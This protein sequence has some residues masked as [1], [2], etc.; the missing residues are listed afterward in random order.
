MRLKPLEAEVAGALRARL[1]LPAPPLTRRHRV[2]LLT[3][4]R[5]RA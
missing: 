3:I 5:R 4:Y 1:F 2:F